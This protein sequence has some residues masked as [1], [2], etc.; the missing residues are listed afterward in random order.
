MATRAEALQA[1]ATSLVDCRFKATSGGAGQ[2]LMNLEQCLRYAMRQSHQLP[3]TADCEGGTTATPLDRPVH[4]CVLPSWP[5]LQVNSTGSAVAELLFF[6]QQ[7]FHLAHTGSQ[8]L[9]THSISDVAQLYFF[10]NRSE[11]DKWMLRTCE[12]RA[13]A[14]CAAASQHVAL[15]AAFAWLLQVLSAARHY[16]L[17]VTA[18]KAPEAEEPPS[19]PNSSA[20]NQAAG[21]IEA[22]A[23]KPIK[24][25]RPQHPP[26]ASKPRSV[27]KVQYQR[28]PEAAEQDKVPVSSDAP[29][30][31]AAE[32]SA[33]SQVAKVE[34]TTAMKL[35]KRLLLSAMQ[36]AYLLCQV[37]EELREP[38]ELRRLH[39]VL[40]NSL[41]PVLKQ[42]LE[43]DE[44]AQARDGQENNPLPAHVAGGRHTTAADLL[45]FV[46][47]SAKQVEGRYEEAV[48][49]FHTALTAGIASPV[50]PPEHTPFCMQQ[51][52]CCYAS[53]N[54]WKRLGD[55]WQAQGLT[56]S[57]GFE[58]QSKLQGLQVWQPTNSSTDSDD[59]PQS[60]LLANCKPL[61]VAAMLD[62]PIMKAHA[63]VS[64]L[65]P[66]PPRSGQPQN[67]ESVVGELGAAFDEALQQLSGAAAPLS[68]NMAA[69][70]VSLMHAG[71]AMTQ[72]LIARLPPGAALP[73]LPQW[74]HQAAAAEDASQHLLAASSMLITDVQQSDTLAACDTMHRRHCVLSDPLQA[75][76]SGGRQATLDGAQ[77]PL[78]ALIFSVACKLA[79]AHEYSVHGGAGTNANLPTKEAALQVLLTVGERSITAALQGSNADAAKRLLTSLMQSDVVAPLLVAG[80]SARTS[81]H[82]QECLLRLQLQKLRY[83]LAAQT[84]HGGSEQDQR[85]GAEL[86]PSTAVPREL[87]LDAL[88]PTDLLEGITASSRS[89]RAEPKRHPFAVTSTGLAPLD[90]PAALEELWASLYHCLQ[91]DGPLLASLLQSSGTH[92]LTAAHHALAAST[93]QLCTWTM[94]AAPQHNR[95]SPSWAAELRNILTQTSMTQLLHRQLTGE[96]RAEGQAVSVNLQALLSTEVAQAAPALT[97]LAAAAV[98][99][100]HD[101]QSAWLRFGDWVYSRARHMRPSR[102]AVRPADPAG[103]SVRAEPELTEEER[104]CYQ[105]VALAYSRVLALSLPQG[106]VDHPRLVLR[107][108]HLAIHYH[109]H[110]MQSQLEAA[111]QMVPAIAWEVVA[112]QLFVQLHHSQQHVRAFATKTLA[113]LAEPAPAAVLYTV[114]AS[115]LGSSQSG[116]CLSCFL[117]SAYLV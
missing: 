105:H 101:L 51:V 82:V 19:N 11:T 57:K 28:K 42:L 56:V 85:A 104:L 95:W 117:L 32:E 88:L 74:L 22:V 13:R 14:A 91:P 45:A 9:A 29:A 3:A 35:P 87:S 41:E 55:G 114:V 75:A 107:L 16:T 5:A 69:E 24:I 61:N 17:V 79:S 96:R 27:V 50:L 52:A 115:A 106:G 67:I 21:G 80:A 18:K 112:P 12:L 58:L 26:E 62:E 77:L 1:I 10:V 93:Q 86:S 8:L 92:S 34:G 46:L 108:L 68:A 2:A 7:R 44:Q 97:C 98:S 54:D 4:C 73:E 31:A 60:R 40:S 84:K 72:L 110:G 70:Y 109:K 39:A 66:A 30:A 111:M 6:L 71:V 100:G 23:P 81:A 49:H 89:R 116:A 83:Q 25:L 48:V 47:G 15:H 94:Q 20:G 53:L 59:E 64:A 65:F 78:Q 90:T 36:L 38:T 103:P 33:A 37:F 76:Y 43:L 102:R 63:C 99:S 113:A